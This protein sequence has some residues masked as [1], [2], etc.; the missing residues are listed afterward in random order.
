MSNRQNF[1]E[2]LEC[3]ADPSRRHEYFRLYSDD[4]VLHGYQGVEPG[5]ESVKR[6]YNS[7]W[8]IFPDACVTVQELIEQGDTLVARYVITGTQRKALMGVPA[9]GQRIELPGISVLHFKGGHCFER[10]ACSDSLFLLNQI[11]APIP[12]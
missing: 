5:L 6:F 9:A 2:A 8:I 10:W 11:G 7:F 12:H 4:I 1:A 3:F